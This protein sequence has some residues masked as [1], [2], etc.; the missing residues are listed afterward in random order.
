MAKIMHKAYY[1]TL[2]E[3]IKKF[4]LVKQNINGQIATRQINKF[5]IPKHRTTLKSMCISIRG[6]KFWNSLDAGIIK[7]N[8]TVQKF[9][10]VL[11]KGYLSQYLS[12]N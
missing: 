7:D 12:Q 10:T 5:V 11:K 3:N 2:P 9:K 8:V 4:F 6:V 1:S